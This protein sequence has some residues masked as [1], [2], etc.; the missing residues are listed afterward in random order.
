MIRLPLTDRIIPALS[1]TAF[2]PYADPMNEIKKTPSDTSDPSQGTAQ[3]PLLQP[4]TLGGV[5]I[6]N[7][8]FSTGHALSHAVSGKPTAT[9]LHY[10]MEKAKG[11]IGLSFV[12]GSSTVSA[13]TAPVFDQFTID[14]EIIPFFQELSG[15]YHNE[16]SVLF[17]QITHLGRRTNANAGSWLPVVAPSPLRETLHR[18]FPREIDRADIDRI[19]ADFA[20]AARYCQEGGLDGLEII[21][22]GHLMDQFWSPLTNQRSDDFGGS[23][24]NRMRFSRMVFEAMRQSVGDDF[25][26]GVRMTMDESGPDGGLSENDNITIAQRLRDDGAIDFLNLVSGR[27]DSMPGLTNYMPGMDAPL[28]PFLEQASRFRREVGLPVFHATRVNDIATARHAIREGLVDMVGMTRGHIADP[29][30]VEKIRNGKEDRIR[31]CVGATYCSN[32]KYCIQNPATAREQ[33]LPHKINP[34]ETKRRVVIVGGGPGGLEAAR[35]CAE[36]GHDVILFEAA[37]QLGGQVILA[38]KPGWRRDLGGIITWLARECEILGVDIRCDSFADAEM[39]AAENPDVVIIATGG[40]PDTDWVEG[41][42]SLSSTW[43]VLSGM[44][45][46]EGSVMIHDRTGRAAALAAADWLADQGAAVTINTQDANIGMECMRLEMTPFMKRIYQKGVAM[47]PDH[48]LV[49]ARPHRN[50]VEVT[51]RNTHTNEEITQVY[52]H[53]VVEAGT[54]PQDEE[55]EALRGD[56]LNNGVI[57]IDRLINA[58]PQPVVAG[59]GYH[60]YRIGDAAGSRDIH[61]AMLDALRLCA[62]L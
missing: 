3:D 17:A 24:E 28:S 13:D 56:A 39:V 44:A 32:F 4:F 43:D 30:I 48:D 60:L 33:T 9:T 50:G 19:V 59:D 16:G 1:E 21:A 11:G 14:R 52:D 34:S 46:L 38:S 41:G 36:R 20:A 37:S 51:L 54:R 26:L 25:I 58:E 5:T 23:L 31:S 55:Y 12:G 18:G 61:C 47:Q 57:D 45:S 40:L 10:Q 22:S 6:R 2:S 8:I 29:Y 49:S 27:I 42:A 62:R 53:L 35:V 7:R 15:F